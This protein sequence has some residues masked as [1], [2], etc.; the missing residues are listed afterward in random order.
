MTFCK[1]QGHPPVCVRH[2]PNVLPRPSDHSAP[3]SSSLFVHSDGYLG[4][5]NDPAG[6]WWARCEHGTR[7][8]GGLWFFENDDTTLVAT[9]LLPPPAI[10]AHCPLLV[11]YF[12]GRICVWKRSWCLCG[13][14]LH[15]YD[16][17]CLVYRNNHWGAP[18]CT[19]QLPHQDISFFSL[20]AKLSAPHPCE[21]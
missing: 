17:S 3:A 16:L 20:R 12:L 18:P 13:M 21:H 1:R 8:Q 7:G 19:Q 4:T 15:W 6:R 9:L 11:S 14:R 2:Q 10:S 5:F